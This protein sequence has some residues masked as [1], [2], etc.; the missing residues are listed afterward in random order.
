[1]VYWQQLQQITNSRDDVVSRGGN[2]ITTGTD[3]PTFSQYNRMLYSV[4][5][6][7]LFVPEGR[8]KLWPSSI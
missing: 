6:L 8:S 4:I 2:C 1:M 3:S 7:F 5:W